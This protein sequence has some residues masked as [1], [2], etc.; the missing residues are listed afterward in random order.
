M[1][2]EENMVLGHIQT[3]GNQGAVLRFHLCAKLMLAFSHVRHM[4][5]A[6]ES[7]DRA[8]PNCH[9]PLSQVSRAEAAY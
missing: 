3:A 1:S 7:K 9:R 4:D 5:E 2:G 6:S 8:A